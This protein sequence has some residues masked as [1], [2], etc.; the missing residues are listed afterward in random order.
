MPDGFPAGLRLDLAWSRRVLCAAEIVDAVTLEPVRKDIIVTA[1]GLKRAPQ[2]NWSGYHVWLEEGSAKPL[3]ISVDASKTDYSDAVS[4]PPVPPNRSVRIELAP[5]FSY[6]F[7]AGATALRGTLIKSRF[8]ARAPVSGAQVRL[9]WSG[10]N[11]WADAPT[12]VAS[13]DNGDFAAPLRFGPK[14]KPNVASGLLTVRL[15]V[16]RGG[17][18]RTSDPFALRRGQVAPAP[19]PFV[20]DDLHP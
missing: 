12:S 6:R 3:R 1:D 5:R 10:D 4:A 18:T 15:R 8:G 20:W 11:G 7:P 13:N 9:Q 17:A 2:V 16:T 19:N 14:D